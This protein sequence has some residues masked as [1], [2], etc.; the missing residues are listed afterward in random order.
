MLKDKTQMKQIASAKLE[1]TTSDLRS[2]PVKEVQGAYFFV[3]GDQFGAARVL[4]GPEGALMRP[5]A[6][7]EAKHVKQ[8]L[9]GQRN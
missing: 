6:V 3:A 1:C 9:A 8:Y 7:S 4:V 5:S 2:W